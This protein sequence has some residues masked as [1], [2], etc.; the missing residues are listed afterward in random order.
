MPIFKKVNHDFFKKWSPEMSY[1]LGFFAVDGNMLKNNRDAHFIEFTSTDREII[2]KIKDVLDAEQKISNRKR[3]IN[4][5]T[6][7]R[8]QIGSKQIFN[9]LLKLGLTPKK[10]KKIKL[11]NI[12]DKYFGDFLRGYFDGDGSVGYYKYKKRGRSK[13]TNILILRFISGSLIFLKDLKFKLTELI[14]T[15]GSLYIKDGNGQLI[16]SINDSKRLFNFMYH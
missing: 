11:P 15:K 9:D 8:I 2:E 16:Y 5:K 7:Y 4:W 6:E 13:T 3:G 1:V 14:G 10:S 12:S